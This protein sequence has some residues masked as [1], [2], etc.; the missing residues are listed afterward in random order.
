MPT[1]TLLDGNFSDT[2]VASG[3][4]ST[5]GSIVWGASDSGQLVIWCRTGSTNPPTPSITGGWSSWSVDATRISGTVAGGILATGT[6]TK[7]DEPI[8]VSYAGVSS[9][10]RTW[11]V[12][13]ITGSTANPLG[14]FSTGGGTA[15]TGTVTL[16][17]T[18][19]AGSHILAF[20]TANA[21]TA[22]AADAGW[23]ELTEPD[24]A[25]P[26][27][28]SVLVLN[29]AADQTYAGSWGSSTGFGW[30][31]WEVKAAPAGLIRPSLIIN[32]PAISVRSTW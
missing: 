20:G 30:I 19:G 10:S 9:L 24:A 26:I 25:V 2:D 28:N 23:T 29:T 22:W 27:L 16:T 32:Q 12:V 11:A 7:T 18:L 13:G 14:I 21:G 1:V 4:T 5:T 17:G 15:T 3:G 8:T 31:I 6:G